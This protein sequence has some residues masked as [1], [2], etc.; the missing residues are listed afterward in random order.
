MR[1]VKWTACVAGILVA[2]FITIG[3]Q[4]QRAQEPDVL[5]ALLVEVR[6]LR[7]ALEEMGTAG[8]RVQLAL[9]RLQLQEQRVNTALRR[10]ESIRD[11]ISKAEREIATQQGQLDAFLKMF[12]EE[13]PGEEHPMAPMMGG[14]KKGIE[15]GALEVQRLQAEEAQLQQ[16]I[17]AEQGRWAE[18]NRA[19]EDLE[20]A[21]GKRTAR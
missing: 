4:G 16:Q 1:L 13:K 18:I 6:G 12:K 5:N 8:P 21:L 10:L 3:A 17:S 9:G 15:A 11:S 2:G 20:K 14:F 7:Q 19:M